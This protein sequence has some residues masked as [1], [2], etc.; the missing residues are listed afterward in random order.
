MTILLALSGGIFSPLA[1]YVLAQIVPDNTLGNESS[2][3]TPLD[4]L[5]DRI[6]GGAARGAN[7]FH[8]FQEFN[9]GE[10][11]GVYFN[12]PALIENILTRVTG[13]NISEIMGRLGVLGEANL[14][15]INPN[16][17]VFGKDATLDIRG[18]FT[19]TTAD[20]IRLGEDGYFSATDT[21][22]SQ[23]LRVNPGAL[24]SNALRNHQAKIG[25]QGNLAVGNGQV[26][27]LF[28]DLV[29]SS[30][31]LSA[32]GGAVLVLGERI[33]LFDNATIDVSSATGGGTVLIGGNV[34]GRGTIPTAKRTYIDTGVN[35]NADA[36]SNGNGGNVIVWA[37]E[38]TGFYGNISA[39]GGLSS[40]NGGFVEVS[41][42]EHL[43]FRGNV[44]TS[45][46]NGLTGTLLLDPKDIII[47]NGTRDSGTDG[48]N[49][50]AGD[51]SNIAGSI[52]SDPLSSFDTA[53]TTIY[54]SEL[55]GL[56]GDTDIILQATNDITVQNL[57]DNFLNLAAGSGLISFTA[58]A[59]GDGIGNFVMEDTTDTIKT[60][61]RDIEISG[62]DLNLG[63][64]NTSH[65][66]A[67]DGGDIS[68]EAGGDITTENLNS[69][70]RYSHSYWEGAG[71]GG[72]IFLEAGGDITTENLNSSSRYSYSYWEG[73]GNGGDIF[74]EAG[75]DITTENLYSYSRYSSSYWRGA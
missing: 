25:N 12:N 47:A 15:L 23:L 66:G 24:F 65:E 61:G 45:A 69:S 22:G 32:P 75:G 8:S 10:G 62:W 44:D 1:H 30:G 42:K 16:G 3:V 55:E 67:G 27:T 64:I 74:L 49:P 48:K 71:N 7:L 35:I 58:D 73:A 9:V 39:R 28:G 53:P 14:F 50:F 6:D 37:D 17:I 54:E 40:G 2:L 43:I 68:L 63:N 57:A 70:S 13:S 60:N 72:D 38:V 34:Q 52:L 36:L 41:G 56:S 46:V 20:G 19:A 5:N 59:D 11:R 33:G 4:L 51:Q 21:Q 31:S 18:S 29:T 26:L